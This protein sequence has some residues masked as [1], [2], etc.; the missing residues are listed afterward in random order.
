MLEI[1][2]FE[3]SVINL[4]SHLSME[5]F[6]IFRIRISKEVK[7][8]IFLL[9]KRNTPYQML[10]RYSDFKMDRFSKTYPMIYINP[11]C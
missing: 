11:Y 7:D 9:T 8:L 3:D 4:P 1:I 10:P 2:A 6:L 5:S